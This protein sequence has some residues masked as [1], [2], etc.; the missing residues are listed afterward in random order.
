MGAIP[1]HVA[2]THSSLVQTQESESCRTAARKTLTSETELDTFFFLYVGQ[3][4]T[5]IGEL[6]GTSTDGMAETLAERKEKTAITQ[7]KG[8]KNL[9]VRVA[10]RMLLFQI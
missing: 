6:A 7:G 5:D 8:R 2:N 9:H 1:R 3:D 10:K 4:W